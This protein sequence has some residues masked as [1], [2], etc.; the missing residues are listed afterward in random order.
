MR[1]NAAGWSLIELLLALLLASLTAIALGSCALALL[2][3]H[4]Q[5]QRLNQLTDDLLL[6]SGFISRELRRSGYWGE[7]GALWL[8]PQHNPFLALSVSADGHCLLY[9]YDLNS[10]GLLQGGVGPS[11]W[12]AQASEAN[13]SERFGIRLRAGALQL[14]KDGAACNSATGWETLTSGNSHIAPLAN[15]PPFALT[16]PAPLYPGWQLRPVLVAVRL[17]LSHNQQQELLR[18]LQLEVVP[19][20]GGAWHYAP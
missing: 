2:H 16:W 12:H 18:P 15:E 14:R 1:L 17:Q 6:A 19:R 11:P 5:Q 3:H 4:Q 10:D 13:P 9:H 8:Q 20:N 7:T